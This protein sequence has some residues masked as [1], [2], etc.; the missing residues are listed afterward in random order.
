MYYSYSGILPVAV[1]AAVYFAAVV[2]VVK[3]IEIVVYLAKIKWKVSTVCQQ[4]QGLHS[5]AVLRDWREDWVF[6]G[7]DPGFVLSQRVC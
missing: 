7:Q 1:F 3:N 4:Y 5:F 2:A 6:V